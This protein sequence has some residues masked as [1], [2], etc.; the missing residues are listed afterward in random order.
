MFFEHDD[1]APV[2]PRIPR[3]RAPLEPTHRPPQQRPVVP[4]QKPPADQQ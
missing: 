2:I 4:R 1:N 3:P